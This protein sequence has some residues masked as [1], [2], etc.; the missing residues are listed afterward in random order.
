[1]LSV[2]GSYLFQDGEITD[3][4]GVIVAVRPG[5]SVDPRQYGLGETIDGVPVSVETADPET[6]ANREFGFV[7]EAFAE[8]K[9]EYQRD[10]TDPKFN[11]DPVTDEMR[12]TLHVSPEAGWPVLE[13]FLERDDAEQ[14]TIGMYHMTA[15]HVVE[16]IEKIAN[17]GDSRIVLTLDR[18][19][20]DGNNPDDTGGSTKD[21]DIP[22]KETL[23]N[24]ENIAGN[25]FKWAPASL[26]SQG[27]FATAY[28]IKVAVWTDRGSG[29]Q[30]RDKRFWLSSGNWQSSNQAP[31]TK[32][33][34]DL[35]WADV[36]E[37]NRE[38]HAIVEHEG[39]ARTFRNHL[40]QDFEDNKDAAVEESLPGSKLELLVPDALLEK[41]RKPKRFEAFEPLELTGRIKVQPLLTP[42]NYPEVVAELI[43]NATER[44]LIENQSFGIWQEV[45]D[46]PDHFVRILD[47][48]K[49][50]QKAGLDVRIIFRSGFGKERD[51]LRRMKEYGIKADSKHVRYFDTCHTKGFVIDDNIAIL[52]SQNITAG[53]TGPNRDAS[54]VIWNKDANKYFAELF[55]YDWTQ[56][57]SAK[58][59]SELASRESIRVVSAGLEAP[60]PA[61]FR[62]I[63]LAEYLGET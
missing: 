30:K 38:W 56:V 49:D 27:L 54:L 26:G 63:S 33:V 40:E 21:K 44:V 11:L 62:R 15:P 45:G 48:I 23:A 10:L 53:G 52:G 7:R 13:G 22:E 25:R 9:A 60:T 4:L 51:T 41:P 43:E 6:V 18:Q 35:T 50:R 24:L 16:A 58:R 29:G 3:D 55:E 12:V 36:G 14:L 59:A 32:A 8:R 1:V 61:G 28:H 47:A 39:L 42:D 31:I 34:Q 20:G 2:R 37:Y 17:R 57:A 46:M 5:E 19:R